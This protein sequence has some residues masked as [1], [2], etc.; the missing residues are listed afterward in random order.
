MIYRSKEASQ[1]HRWISTT[2]R[3]SG[4]AFS[5]NGETIATGGDDRVVMIWDVATRQRRK[6][7]SGHVLFV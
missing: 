3:F 5:P 6:V 4:I 1:L 2:G 7:L